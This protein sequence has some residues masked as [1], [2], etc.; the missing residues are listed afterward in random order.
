MV[1][2]A[3]LL[4][5]LLAPASALASL[6]FEEGV[7]REP[8]SD[9][10]LY[11]E[12]HLVRRADGEP[13]ERLVIYRC[14]DGTPFARKRVDYRG[15]AVAPE[16]VFEDARLGYGEGLRRRTGIE[17][18]WVREGKGAAERS[19]ALE[20]DARLVADAGF[21]EFIRDHWTP[22]VAG[23]SVPLR[24]A[25]PSRLQSLGFKVDRQGSTE[26]AGEPAESFRLRLG[27]LLGWL[28][29]HIDVAY[30]RDSR[31]LLR[32]EGLSNLRT[33]DGESQLVARIEFPTPARAASEAQ[34][35]AFAGQPLSACR[36]RG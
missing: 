7:A 28:A 35:Q 21:D 2:P 19:A 32:F 11:L 10:L 8:D 6:T 15:S 36:V 14:G 1:K 25:V 27:G 24:F 20:D 29:P 26:F 34:W 18:V 13:T 5:C 31:R 3:L 17:Q 9:R 23:E 30:G 22:L 33:D 16:F 4:A 12:Q